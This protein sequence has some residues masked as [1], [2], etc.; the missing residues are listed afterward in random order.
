MLCQVLSCHVMFCSVLFC[1]EGGRPPSSELD[2]V[3]ACNPGWIVRMELTSERSEGESS[4][5]SLSR[6]G[7]LGGS[8]RTSSTASPCRQQDSNAL[9]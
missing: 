1:S 9:G 5:R 8:F 6:G 7:M 3:C 2:R 4:W